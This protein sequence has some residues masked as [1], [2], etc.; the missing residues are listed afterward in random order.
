MRMRISELEEDK[1][2]EDYT[3][4][5]LKIMLCDILGRKVKSSISTLSIVMEKESYCEIKVNSLIERLEEDY[6]K[7]I[8]IINEINGLMDN[9]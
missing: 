4:E 7:Y 6:A 5:Q 9:K 1:L 2:N 8:N 3:N